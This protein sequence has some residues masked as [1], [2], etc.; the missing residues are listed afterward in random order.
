MLSQEKLPFLFQ[1][2]DILNPFNAI[3][4]TYYVETPLPCP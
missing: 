4:E 1:Q 3:N 2:P